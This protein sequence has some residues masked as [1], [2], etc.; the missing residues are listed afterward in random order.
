MLTK[1]SKPN[2]MDWY[3]TETVKNILVGMICI[4]NVHNTGKIDQQ[5]LTYIV[6]E[7]KK[8]FAGRA[9]T[10]SEAMEMVEKAVVK[11]KVDKLLAGARTQKQ[12]LKT[13]LEN[14]NA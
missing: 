8:F 4:V 3:L 2:D 5:F 11:Y 9:T 1:W 10:L 12:D 6:D 13:I 14:D 7:N